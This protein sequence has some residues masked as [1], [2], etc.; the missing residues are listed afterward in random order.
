MKLVKRSEWG[1][2]QP[3]EITKL[4]PSQVKGV[5]VH[6]SAA[7]SDNVFHHLAC[8]SRVRGIQ[9]YHMDSNGWNDIAYN[10]LVCKHGYV[11]EGRGMFARCAAQG[12]NEGNSSYLAVC[13]LGAD[14]PSRD[15]VTP[16][17]RVALGETVRSVLAAYR[18]SEIYPHSHFNSTACPGNELRSFIALRGWELEDANQP[19][20]KWFWTWN[21]WRLGEG[22]WKEFGPKGG[23]RPKTAPWVI[24]R[25]AWKKAKAFDEARDR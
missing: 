8:A 22:P 5:A 24:P 7:E 23:Q 20:P 18:A 10:F 4:V 12:T 6:Y 17:G 21:A 15:D 3:T 19:L 11:F 13:F 25:W 9:N 16:V 1:A 14:S 2:R